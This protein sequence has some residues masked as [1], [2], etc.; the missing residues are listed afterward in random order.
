M[1]SNRASSLLQSVTLILGTIATL[2]VHGYERAYEKTPVGSI[3]VRELPA[4][5]WITTETEGRYFERS[6]GLFMRLF[7]YIKA[8]DISMTVPVRGGLTQAEMRFYLGEDAASAPAETDVIRVVDEPARWVASVGAR[9]AYTENN[10]NDAKQELVAWLDRKTEWRAD[11]EPYAVFW[12]GPFTP[13]F[14]KRFEVHVPIQPVSRLN[15]LET[16]PG[17]TVESHPSRVASG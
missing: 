15:R 13:W 11:G 10:L 3:E 9:G 16:S 17:R 14:I 8:H 1:L 12:N 4:G 6:D 2:T 5:R 7:D